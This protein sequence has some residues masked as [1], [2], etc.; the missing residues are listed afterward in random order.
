MG[1]IR[2]LWYVVLSLS[3]SFA[4]ILGADELGHLSGAGEDEKADQWRFSGVHGSQ[5]WDKK[6]L[7]YT[8]KQTRYLARDWKRDF[9]LPMPPA[10]S[11]ERTKAELEYLMTLI[12]ERKNH[13][14]EIE[15][16]V[17]VSHFRWGKFTYAQLTT[18]KR[19]QHTSK[20]IVEAYSDLGVVCFWFK[21]KFNRVRPSL[22]AER[23]GVKLGTVVAIPGHPAYPSGH[24]TGAYTIAYLLQELDPE[25]AEV[26]RK[27]A[28]R[29]AKNREIGGLHYPSDTEAGRLLARQ[30][31]DSLLENKGY[32]R[33]LE[34]AREEW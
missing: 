4:G 23:S 15:A 14:K 3:L 17:I 12:P 20:L 5:K 26:Y 34:K 29:M 32:L 24:A 7:A 27:D 11:S 16:E 2:S 21:D 31:V 30:I 6:F 25:N 28:E 13:E 8:R 22:L 18:D 33:I 9:V 10:N 19:Y 1:M